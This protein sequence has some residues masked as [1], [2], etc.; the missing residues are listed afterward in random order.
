MK[1][2]GVKTSRI[3]LTEIHA[4]I[5][6]DDGL[7]EYEDITVELASMSN[8]DWRR[9]IKFSWVVM[10][11]HSLKLGYFILMYMADRYGIRYRDLISY[12]SDER[13]PRAIAPTFYRELAYY[14]AKI[15]DIMAGRGRACELPEFGAIYWD[16]EEA[17]VLRVSNDL[18]GFYD[19][20]RAVLEAFLVDRGIAFDAD[21][22][23]QAVAFQRMRFPAPTAPIENARAFDWNFPEYFEAGHLG[24]PVTLE[25]ADQTLT[26]TDPRDFAGDIVRY[27]R[28]VILWGRKSDR[29]LERATWDGER[30]GS[31]VEKFPEVAAN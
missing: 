8:A 17:T 5:R 2:H 4:K 3:R 21:E 1:K 31:P 23:A 12:I 22:L 15:E 10:A 13:I 6:P 30:V 29:L 27:A 9:M 18:D 11:L 20:F 16:V 7:P 26:L 19:E 24:K 14:D 28:E 25:P